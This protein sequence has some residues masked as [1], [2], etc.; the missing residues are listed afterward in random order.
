[1]LLQLLLLTRRRELKG[2]DA[3]AR[4]VK[5]GGLLTAFDASLPFE[6]TA[7]QKAVAAKR[8]AMTWLNLI[9]CTVCCKEK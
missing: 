4:P 7:G 3:V 5:E 1:L 2:L 6:L 9:P 8:S